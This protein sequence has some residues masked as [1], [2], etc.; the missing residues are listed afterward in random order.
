MFFAAVRC[1]NLPY[2]SY[3][4]RKLGSSGPQG[5]KVSG[6]IHTQSLMNREERIISPTWKQKNG[7]IAIKAQTPKTRLG[8]E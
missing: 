4:I 3:Q 5:A 7:K 2:Y 8:S 6:S 1:F